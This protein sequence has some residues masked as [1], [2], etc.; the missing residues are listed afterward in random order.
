MD[1]PRVSLVAL[2]G[3]VGRRTVTLDE[4][5][6]RFDLSPEKITAKTGVTALRRL[7]DDESLVGLARDLARDVLAR[8]GVRPGEVRAVFGSSNPTGENLLPT[9]VASAAQAI[10]LRDVIVDH[11]GIGCCGGLQAIRNAYNQLVVDAL[12][13]RVSHCLVIAGDHTSRILDPDRRQ[14]GTLFGEGVSVALLT[15]APSADAYEIVS[16][17]TKSLLGDALESLRIK[18]PFARAQPRSTAECALE[19][20]GARIFEFGAGVFEHFVGLVGGA[21]PAGCY[22]VPHQ[23][24]LRMLEAMIA[25]AGLE[26]ARVYVDGIQTVGNT[27]AAAAMLGLEDALGRD[28]VGSDAHVLLGAFG[29]ELQVGAAM[30]RPVGDPR[31]VLARAAR[32]PDEREEEPR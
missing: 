9:F 26:P 18:N 5:A 30:L 19:M 21:L 4:L 28:L 10:G 32:E 27:S 13:G 1:R 15:N 24:N 23:P 20:E 8:A 14:T 2:A 29:A 31:R 12:D 17:G 22:V 7:G 3:A 11:V 6:R 25:R 16:V